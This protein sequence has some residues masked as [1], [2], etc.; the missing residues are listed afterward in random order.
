MI[1]WYPHVLTI[2]TL[3]PQGP[4]KTLNVVEFY[5][6]E[7]V[8]AFERDLVESQRAAYLETC[9]EDDEIA[10]RMD[11]GRKALYERGDDEFGPYQNPMEEGMRHFHLWY[12]QQ[13]GMGSGGER[14]VFG[15]KRVAKK[16]LGAV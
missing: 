3:I 13:M 9:A 16:V 7:E 10:E 2:S 11:A 15:E 8:A 5:Y 1:E 14:D 4:Q 12:R 6:P